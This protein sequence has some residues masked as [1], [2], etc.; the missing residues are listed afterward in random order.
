MN[1]SKKFWHKF[2]I[3]LPVVLILAMITMIYITYLIT[4]IGVLITADTTNEIHF[5]LKFT[6]STSN[7]KPK[8]YILLL[9]TF[10]LLI[11]LLFSIIK[12]VI[13]NPGYFPDPMELE[14]KLISKSL[15][16]S[17]EENTENINE[18]QSIKANN[19][20]KN[21]NNNTY[22]N[23]ED[24]LDLDRDNNKTTKIKH[25]NNSINLINVSTK[26]DLT[27][28]NINKYSVSSNYNS[29]L[30][31]NLGL[32]SRFSE[33]VMDGPVNGTEY[34][35]YSKNIDYFYDS[36]KNIEKVN[37]LYYPP[38]KNNEEIMD[39][40]KL[41]LMEKKQDCM[42]HEEFSFDI[43]D[44]FKGIDLS[45][46]NQCGSCQ[47]I[48]VERSHHCKMC[49]KCV[50]KMDHH[51][52]WLANCIGYY[53]FKYFCLVHIYGSL[54]T[55]IITM[56]YWET[57][58]NLNMNYNSDIIQCWFVSFVYVTNFALMSFLMWLLYVNVR[59]V[60]N[61]ETIIEQSDR[62]RFPSS[63]SFNPYDMGWKRNF[64]NVFGDNWLTWFLP[65]FP[66]YKGEGLIFETKKNFFIDH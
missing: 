6:T 5:L 7:S 12:T 46:L 25:E 29:K 8:G 45:K 24:E 21:L 52:P 27:N 19:R 32:I 9:I 16:S 14:L 44:I 54:E 43:S 55:F 57:L 48:K 15:N 20:K 66:N 39:N 10:I 18:N 13:T 3:Y 26:Q 22:I 64:T 11:L 51:C 33:S 49:Q 1:S 50:L 56:S 31:E 40:N 41:E 53:N 62:E 63:K 59:L 23:I 37:S 61:G 2:L 47:R 36:R 35:R 60:L 28:R 4:Y 30:F 17:T 34:I 58:V 65:G 42:N 38:Q